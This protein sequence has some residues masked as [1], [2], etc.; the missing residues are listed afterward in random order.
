M[1]SPDRTRRPLHK[2]RREDSEGSIH[3]RCVSM[4]QFRECIYSER[5]SAKT[6]TENLQRQIHAL[7]EV[8]RTLPGSG[9]AAPLDVS[10]S[11]DV[12]ASDPRSMSEGHPLKAFVADRLLEAEWGRA[13]CGDVRRAYVHWQRKTHGDG[14]PGLHHIAFS[15]EMKK[16]WP[17]KGCQ[18]RRYYHGIQLKEPEMLP[19]Q[20]ILPRHPIEGTPVP[21]PTSVPDD[22][23]QSY[24]SKRWPS[25]GQRQYETA[26]VSSASTTDSY[27]LSTESHSL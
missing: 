26:S 6:T 2:R 27:P 25:S 21:L 20:K 5:H 18:A 12:I 22:R 7:Q 4:S 15:Q 11:P 19:S 23:G 14:K 16:H 1:S 9:P 10:N 8:I 17:Q 24:G 13:R 3:A